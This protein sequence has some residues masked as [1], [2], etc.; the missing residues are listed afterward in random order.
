MACQS[1]CSL[2]KLPNRSLLHPTKSGGSL[3]AVTFRS[4]DTVPDQFI[5]RTTSPPAWI[6]RDYPDLSNPM[7]N[8]INHTN[9]ANRAITWQRCQA[10]GTMYLRCCYHVTRA[11]VFPLG[12]PHFRFQ[13]LMSSTSY[14]T[15]EACLVHLFTSTPGR[16]LV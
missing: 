6:P 5:S 11:T 7:T 4:D 12:F 15:F 2:Q 14:K 13:D 3:Q 10:L 9:R 1:W 16:V 8:T